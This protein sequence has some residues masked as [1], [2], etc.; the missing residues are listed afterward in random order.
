MA[1]DEALRQIAELAAKLSDEDLRALLEY[2]SADYKTRIKVAAQK[3]ALGLRQG[4][5][6]ENVRG[7]RK[8]PAGARGHVSEVRGGK[9]VVHFPDYGAWT[10]D[11][12][13]IRK[14]GDG[15]K[16]PALEK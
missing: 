12:T 6:V 13:M 8:L 7:G 11:A 9:V 14:V 15:S 10:V 4:D 2:L 5:E 16:P 1:Q 3:A